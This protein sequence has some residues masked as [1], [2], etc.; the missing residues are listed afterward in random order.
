MT[1][2]LNQIPIDNSRDRVL[3]MSRYADYAGFPVKD[4]VREVGY[5]VTK[6]DYKRAEKIELQEQNQ[7]LYD[8][9]AEQDWQRFRNQAT[10]T[11]LESR[12]AQLEQQL[13]QQLAQ[14]PAQQP[15]Q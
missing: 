7:Y 14:Q 13:A 10:I 1:T 6:Y 12:I 9:K 2:A 4:Y 8:N 15:A 3:C 5:L 11:K